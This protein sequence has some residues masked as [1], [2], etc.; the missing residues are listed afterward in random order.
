ML[1]LLYIRNWTLTLTD[2]K[3][4]VIRQILS[5]LVKELVFFSF[6]W[7]Y[8]STLNKTVR[9]KSRKLFLDK[10]GMASEESVVLRWWGNKRTLLLSTKVIP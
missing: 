9:G 5:L 2:R 8:L 7:G 6:V 1:T 4:R 10:R 3:T